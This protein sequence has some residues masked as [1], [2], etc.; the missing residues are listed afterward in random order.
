MK[1]ATPLPVNAGEAPRRQVAIVVETDQQGRIVVTPDV[2]WVHKS[3]RDEAEWFCLRRHDHNDPNDPCFT[4][5]FEPND[6]P[7]TEHTFKNDRARSGTALV[8]AGSKVYKY[9]VRI[10]NQVLDPGGGVKP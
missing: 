2:F 3:E 4:V 10:G 7:F 1:M 6:K 5:E 8:S 9:S